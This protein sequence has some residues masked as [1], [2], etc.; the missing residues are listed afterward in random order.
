VPGRGAA[1]G[2]GGGRA[3]GGTPDAGP[4]RSAPTA[5]QPSDAVPADGFEDDATLVA[6][7]K[8][9][10]AAFGPLYARYLPAVLRYCERRLGDRA[11]AEDVTSQV[12]GRALANLADC[13]EREGAFRG[14][15]FAIARNAVADAHRRRRPSAPRADA[16]EVADAGPGPEDLALAA[17]GQRELRTLLDHLTPDQRR[18]VELRLAGLSGPEIAAALGLSHAAVKVH[19]FRAVRRL[20]GVIAGGARDFQGGSHDGLR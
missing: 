8:A 6:R 11:A 10:R 12:F 5:G 14:W 15:L 20:R 3:T 2:A 9:D 17:E 19:Q 18:V 1:R 13:G 7:A 16:G 4:T